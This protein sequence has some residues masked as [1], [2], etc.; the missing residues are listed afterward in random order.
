M[1]KKPATPKR[2]SPARGSRRSP[3]T[4][5]KVR[6][7]PP[8]KAARAPTPRRA[9]SRKAHRTPRTVAKVS[10]HKDR[11]VATYI[12]Q[13]SGW[14]ADVL[15]ALD[16]LVRAAAPA[17]SASIKWGQPVYDSRGPIAYL[18]AFPTSVNLGFWRG[19]DFEDS[20][21]LL[22]GDGARMRHLRIGS[23]DE[24]DPAVIQGF[25]RQAVALNARL[26]DPTKR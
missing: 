26:G 8:T 15:Q 9:T 5:D 25:V 14:Q 10:L 21:G 3:A 17:V 18:K 24:V 4:L 7:S 19:A 16:G 11:E 20:K 1:P 6:T 22:Q 13:H 2:A 23:I 12:D